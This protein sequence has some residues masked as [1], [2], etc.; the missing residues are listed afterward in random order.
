MW[1]VPGKQTNGITLDTLTYTNQNIN[2]KTTDCQNQ[3][4]SG[5]TIV[6]I[7]Y[8][9]FK[10][11][12]ILND[13]VSEKLIKTLGL[14]NNKADTN[15]NQLSQTFAK[16][17]TAFKSQQP[18]SSIIYSLMG[19]GK[20]IRQDSSLVTLQLNGYIFQGGAHGGSSVQF[21]NW[22]TKANKSITLSDIL[23]NGYQ[24]KLTTVADTIFRKSE[25]LSDTSSLKHDYFFKDDKFA[26]NNNFLITPVGLRFLYNQYEIKHYAA[27]QTN[28]LIPYAK[29][30]SLLLPHTV[31]SQYIK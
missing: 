22:N 10:G 1:G 28:L 2:I 23:V 4:D 19:S 15:L 17:Y 9:V 18:K 8:P 29:I 21:I 16:S 5:C 14:D 24:K 6:K 26:L 30:K 20:I 12:G 11:G 25:K 31:V 13:M 27:G 7:E 3:A